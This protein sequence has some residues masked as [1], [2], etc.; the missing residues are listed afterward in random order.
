MLIVTNST[1]LCVKNF[2]HSKK[3]IKIMLDKITNKR[4]NKGTKTKTNQKKERGNGYDGKEN[5]KER[6]VR[7]GNR[8]C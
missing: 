3:K 1:R 6:N 7:T 2:T 4:Y 5:D 8:G